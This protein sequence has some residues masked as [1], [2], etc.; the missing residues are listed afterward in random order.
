MLELIKK[1][2]FILIIDGY[3]ASHYLQLPNDIKQ[4]YVVVVPRTTSHYSNVIVAM[5]QNLIASIL[6]NVTIDI[7]MINEAELEINAQGYEF[8]RDGWLNIVK[9]HNGKL[10]LLVMGVEEGRIINPQTPIISITN[11]DEL[12]A[13]LPSY[14]ETWVQSIIWKMSSTATLCHSIK[15]ILNDYCH[16]TGTDTKL[17][18]NMLIYFGDRSASSPESAILSG[19]A[20]AV[21]FD[22]SDSIQTNGYIKKIYHTN[23]NY[24][25]SIDASEHG[26]MCANSDSI[27]KNDYGAAVMAVE[28]LEACVKRSKLGIGYP[29]FSVV[30]DTYN[31]RRFVQEFTGI[32][33]KDR[34]LE[35][36]GVLVHRPD[37]GDPTIEPG[38]VANDLANTFGYTTNEKGYRSLHHSVKV[39]QGD[40]MNYDSLISVLDG[41]VDAGYSLDSLI[42]GMGYGI[43]DYVKRDDF[44]FSV[45]STLMIRR[46]GELL[47]LLKNPSTDPNKKSLTG[48][49]RCIE[50]NGVLRTLDCLDYIEV[51]NNVVGVY[52]ITPGWKM[53][54]KNGI[55]T[56]QNF[57]EV[58]LRANEYLNNF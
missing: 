58:R 17:V 32:H 53:W 16:K 38:L 49:V 1:S 30:I 57:D 19:V 5:G 14:I 43:S 28:R 15:L 8:N 46:T 51:D 3:K 54:Y 48:F 10:P 21:F 41:W 9:Y 42:L 56:I 50:E 25:S 26:T 36:G 55:R 6:E 31:P 35:S 23:K 47:K 7:D 34:I 29:T 22:G 18:D 52:D 33:L 11:T 4:N 44:S 2:N 24:T 13:W 12:S 37:S 40:G 45:K 27:N 39:I 20:H